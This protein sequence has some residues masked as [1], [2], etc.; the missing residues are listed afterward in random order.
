[1]ATDTKVIGLS[2][3]PRLVE[4][5]SRYSAIQG[6][7]TKDASKTTQEALKHPE[8]VVV[9]VGEQPLVHGNVLG[10]KDVSCKVTFEST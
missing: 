10:G 7:L 8:V 4:V 5:F 3:R 2:I 6:R 1:M 9:I